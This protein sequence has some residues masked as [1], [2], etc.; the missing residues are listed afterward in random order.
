MKPTDDQR[1]TENAGNSLPKN[2]SV[3]SSKK[4]MGHKAAKENKHSVAD[5]LKK[6]AKEARRKIYPN[7]VDILAIIGILLASTLIAGI[8]GAFLLNNSEGNGG[9]IETAIYFLQFSLAIVFVA[10]QRRARGAK[11]NIVSF[12]SGRLSAPLILWGFLLM[13]VTGIV[14]EPIIDLFPKE[15]MSFLYNAIGT[16]GWAILTTVVLAPIMEETLFRGLI[17]GSIAEKYGPTAGIFLSALIFGLIHGIPQQVVNAFFIGIILGYI[18]YRTKSLLTVIILHFLNNGIA[19]LQ[20]EL[21]GENA[22]NFSTRSFIGNENLYYVIYGICLALM[23]VG[24]IAIIRNLHLQDKQQKTG[25]A[26]EN[27]TAAE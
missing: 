9:F 23:I 16:G 13:M 5:K 26:A 2:D 22:L 20:L 18:Y 12:V 10:L 19:F 3:L 6:S 4:P 21:L 11:A 17:Q 25:K 27:I 7:G 1:P 14:I 8:A 24:A 15:Y